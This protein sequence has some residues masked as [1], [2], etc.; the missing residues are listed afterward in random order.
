MDASP[1]SFIVRFSLVEGP[2]RRSARNG[3]MK[4][5]CGATRSGRRPFFGTG[6]QSISDDYVES[7]AGKPWENGTVSRCQI[8]MSVLLYERRNASSGRSVA[9]NDAARSCL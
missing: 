2:G 5:P 6:A 4:R 8:S 9:G 3:A 1:L 7:R